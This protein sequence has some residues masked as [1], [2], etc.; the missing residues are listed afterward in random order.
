MPIVV[1]RLDHLGG[2]N[3]YAYE[4][5]MLAFHRNFLFQDEPALSQKREEGLEMIE[6][7]EEKHLSF[8][9]LFSLKS[10]WVEMTQR[11]V[12]YFS[13]QPFE[14]QEVVQSWG[15]EVE[16]LFTLVWQK[17]S[18]SIVYKKQKNYTAKLLEFWV[19]HTF[20]PLVLFL[21]K[22]YQILHAS[23]VQVGENAILFAAFSGGGKSTLTNYFIEQGHVV[24]GDDTIALNESVKGYDVIASY[25]FHR[26]FRKPE[27]LGYS[28]ENFAKD[29]HHLGSMYHLKKSSEDAEVSI[30][31][32][33]GMEKFEVVYQ[34][35]FVTF[36]TM[37]VARYRLA[38]KMA[39]AIRVFQIL[40][41]WNKNR[42]EDVYQAILTHNNV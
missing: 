21:D 30:V 10:P 38:A 15:F 37:K 39:Q 2:D 16:G 12:R 9:S 6:V 18:A 32:L 34:S 25:P 41:P 26:P 1:N 29:P 31:E 7:K 40:I 3:I 20:F 5:A 33:H 4:N 27:V 36:G 17:E 23:G 11:R 14:S 42:L 28:I 22:T 8:S 13:N 35:M 24:Y 19:L